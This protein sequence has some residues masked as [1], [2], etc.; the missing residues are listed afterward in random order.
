LLLL[1]L[2]LKIRSRMNKP[3]IYFD[4][5]KLVAYQRSVQFF[6]WANQI[7]EN[8]SSKLD[9]PV[10]CD[11]ASTSVPL[12]IRSISPERLG[13]AITVLALQRRF[14][15]FPLFQFF[16][17]AFTVR[18]VGLI[19]APSMVA[20]QEQKVSGLA[21]GLRKTALHEQACLRQGQ[22]RRFF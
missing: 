7:L 14:K 20:E 5:E 21:F 3:Q 8:V 10:Q 9:V 12:N 6:V 1:L 2:L 19:V 11:R 18:A 15:R 4:R 13:E 16:E 17:A 22:R